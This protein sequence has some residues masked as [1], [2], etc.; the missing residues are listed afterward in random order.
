MSDNN[1]WLGGMLVGAGLSAWLMLPFIIVKKAPRGAVILFGA[2]F[3]TC[4]ALASPVLKKMALETEATGIMSIAG[5][6][7]PTVVELT[8]YGWWLA[9]GCWLAF[10]II[11]ARIITSRK[12]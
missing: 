8:K 12:Y 7:A 1:N 10:V 3:F 5:R 11:A 2:V 9:G 4:F 6:L